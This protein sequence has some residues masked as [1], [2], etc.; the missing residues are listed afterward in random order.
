[1]AYFAVIENNVVENVIVADSLEIAQSVTGK[2]C[3]EYTMENPTGIG[4]TW[5]GERFIKPRPYPSWILGE[6]F[7]WNAPVPRPVDDN[8]YEWNEEDQSWVVVIN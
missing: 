5:D 4:W 8:S 3:I 2:L 1:M 7:E 6:D